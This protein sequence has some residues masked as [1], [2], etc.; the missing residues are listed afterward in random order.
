MRGI[1]ALAT[2]VCVFVGSAI[3]VQADVKTDQKISPRRRSTTS[4]S[5]TRATR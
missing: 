3:A 5:G 4:A 1:R 2:I